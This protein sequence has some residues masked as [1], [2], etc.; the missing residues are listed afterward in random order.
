MAKQQRGLGGGGLGALLGGQQLATGEKGASPYAHSGNS[1]ETFAATVRSEL[2]KEIPLAQIEPNRS[3]PRTKFN[4]EALTE[5]AASI[6]QFGIIQ[7]LTVREIAPNRYQI[8]SGER[9][10]RAS[11]SIGLAEVPAYIRT[12]DD[13]EV[14]EMALVENIQR[15]DLDALEIALSYQ[16]LATEYNL[17]QEDIS[18]RVGKKRSTVANYLRLLKLPEEIQVAIRENLISMGHARA[19]IN[20]SDPKVQLSAAKKIVQQGLSVRATEEL[21]KK[22]S[23]PKE[24]KTSN[25][26]TEALSESFVKL[27][28]GMEKVFGGTI[29]VKRGL[30]GGA[31]LTI[32]FKTDE[33][34]DKAIKKLK[35]LA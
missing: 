19:I 15:E 18:S 12:A 29:S 21:V 16:L 14:L 9:R 27:T 3:Q 10:Y 32:E 1:G 17:T 33:D 20:V 6:K 25:E 11:R 7:P 34:I 5:L 35:Q 23:Q 26:P 28:E 30:N 2:I 13:Q 8:I 4:D 22:L 24:E 31:K